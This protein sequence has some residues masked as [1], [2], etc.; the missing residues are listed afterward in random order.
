MAT[1]N[2]FDVLPKKAK[3]RYWEGYRKE[4]DPPLATMTVR[5]LETEPEVIWH[6]MKRTTTIEV[7]LTPA[8][9]RQHT[10]PT[11]DHFRKLLDDNKHHIA[12]E[13]P[14]RWPELVITHEPE[15]RSMGVAYTYPQMIP[16]I[17]INLNLS[18]YKNRLEF[19]EEYG[20]MTDDEWSVFVFAHELRHMYQCKQGW[21][22]TM[23]NLWKGEKMPWLVLTQKEYMQ[24]PSEKDAN[25]A[26]FEVIKRMR[27]LKK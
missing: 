9:I 19:E 21:L 10:V 16:H 5:F 27:G 12:A 26:A 15:T 1:V 23:G 14:I 22:N 18:G 11:E 8:L 13:V 17:E 6:P 7:I 4:D 25:D 20:E 3:R 2:W 24:R